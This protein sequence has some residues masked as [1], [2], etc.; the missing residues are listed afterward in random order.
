MTA[1]NSVE[2]RRSVSMLL[3][4]FSLLLAALI[5][6]RAA[7]FIGAI[8]ETRALARH[9]IIQDQTASQQIREKTASAQLLAEGLKKK[10][11][12]VL[13]APR[14]HPVK[15]VSGILGDEA[16]ISD[17]WYKCRDKIGEAT[18][19]R[20]GPTEVSIEW[21]GNERTFTPIKGG[22]PASGGGS[23]PA[24]TP[25]KKENSQ[26]A[27]MV[28]TGQSMVPPWWINIPFQDLSTQEQEKLQRLKEHWFRMS[29]QEQQDVMN[30]LHKR[31]GE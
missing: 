21:E 31:F 18:I 17:K 30:A 4:A 15:D 26:Y 29:E 7:M 16:L 14:E 22:S 19:V 27:Q 1:G 12:F 9:V 10:N 20:I 6:L 23:K 2:T 3:L 25:E 11:L 13:P 8:A 5:L 28:I 24:M